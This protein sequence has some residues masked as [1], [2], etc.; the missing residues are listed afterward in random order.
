[1]NRGREAEALSVRLPLR[2][3]SLAPEFL[4][5]ISRIDSAIAV[6]RDNSE[7]YSARAWQLNEIGQPLLALAD[8]QRAVQLEANSAGGLVEQSYALT[9]LGRAQE[10]FAQIKQATQVN[11]DLAPAWQYRGELEMARG[12]NLAAVESFTHALT[13]GKSSPALLKREECYRR[14]GLRARAD[15]DHRALLELTSRGGP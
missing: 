8:A 5:T 6:E 4:E 7:H 13:I 12:D 1:L 10:A 14:L 11:A 3:D 2:L 9:K 15:E